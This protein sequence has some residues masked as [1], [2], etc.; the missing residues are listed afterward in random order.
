MKKISNKNFFKNPKKQKTTQ[1]QQQQQQ[2]TT[3]R[4]VLKQ[5][6]RT[7]PGISS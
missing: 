3:K 6:L 1:Q 7:S 2:T 5:S 4:T